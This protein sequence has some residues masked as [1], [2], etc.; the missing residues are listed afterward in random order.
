M[1]GYGDEVPLQGAFE[2]AWHCQAIGFPQYERM[3]DFAREMME[4]LEQNEVLVHQPIAGRSVGIPGCKTVLMLG[5]STVKQLG[6]GKYHEMLMMD[7]WG[8]V[9]MNDHEKHDGPTLTACDPMA[10]RMVFRESMMS[11]EQMMV[12]DQTTH[13]MTPVKPVVVDS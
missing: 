6:E 12:C 3:T 11:R 9:W 8:E 7:A 4:W 13:G 5:A 2:F 10:K 1:I